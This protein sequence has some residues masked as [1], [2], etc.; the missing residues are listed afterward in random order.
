MP[1]HESDPDRWWEHASEPVRALYAQLRATP[2]GATPALPP[3]DDP[4]DGAGHAPPRAPPRPCRGWPRASPRCPPRRGC[5]SRAAR[6]RPGRP[7]R[8]RHRRHPRH[9]R[10]DRRRPRARGRAGLCLVAPAAGRH[11]RPRRRLRRHRPGRRGAATAQVEAELGPID[12]L[13]NNAGL[14]GAWG[15]FHEVPP[16]V[17]WRDFEVNLRGAALPTRASCPAWSRAA[18]AGWRRCR[19]A[20]PTCRTGTAPRTRRPSARWWC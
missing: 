7:G 17:W 15:L 3:L 8:R 13:V 5:G 6:G 9:R 10:H 2:P 1:F 4:A 11:P 14:A 18:T 12:L 20:W 19:A 16:E